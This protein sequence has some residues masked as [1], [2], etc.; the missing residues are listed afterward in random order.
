MEFMT[1]LKTLNPEDWNVK[2]TDKWTVKNIVAH[3]IGW[4][5]GFIDVVQAFMRN[6]KQPWFYDMDQWDK[7]NEQSIDFY[8]NYSS[9]DLLAEWE[10]WQRELRKII[11]EFG[12]ER[13]RAHPKLV[14][15]IFDESQDSHYNEHLNQIKQA[16]GKE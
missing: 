3:M 2:V 14:K 6:E 10:K 16:L 1:Y 13:L 9:A 5:K 15:W 12:E 11:D 4:E 7:F 8:K